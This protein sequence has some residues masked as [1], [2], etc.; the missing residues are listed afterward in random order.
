MWLTVPSLRTNRKLALAAAGGAGLPPCPPQPART[1]TTLATRT[2]ADRQK[3]GGAGRPVPGAEQ[4][5]GAARR[6]RRRAAA[7]PAAA[8]QDSHDA[9][10]D[11]RGQRYRPGGSCH[12]DSGSLRGARPRFGG[13]LR[14]RPWLAAAR[15]ARPALAGTAI[16]AGRARTWV[17]C[18]GN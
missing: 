2:L 12:G 3:V 16:A 8:G 6:G 5:A 15:S 7:V 13:H 17:R 11:H 4:E 14:T 1:V 18:Y 9:R 10:H